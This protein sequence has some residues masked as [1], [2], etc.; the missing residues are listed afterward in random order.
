MTELHPQAN[1]DQAC[2]DHLILQTYT[3]DAKVPATVLQAVNH[4]W[5]I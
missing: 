1:L 5:P 3:F 4:R 2:Q